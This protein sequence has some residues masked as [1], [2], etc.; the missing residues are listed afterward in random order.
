MDLKF[1]HELRHDLLDLNLRGIFLNWHG[2]L[3]RVAFVGMLVVMSLVAVP[4]WYG[5]VVMWSVVARMAGPGSLVVALP[6]MGVVLAANAFVAGCLVA[7]RLHDAE[8]SG[9]HVWWLMTVLVPA[10]LVWAMEVPGGWSLA[11][12][13]VGGVLAAALVMMPGSRDVNRYGTVDYWG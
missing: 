10:A 7:K 2:R 13:I 11:L 12:R 1:R 9:V 8:R 4:A 6:V 3:S 5:M